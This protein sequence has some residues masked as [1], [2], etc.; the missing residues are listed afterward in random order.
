MKRWILPLL[1]LVLALALAACGAS[2]NGVAAGPET[3]QDPT[4]QSG[5][6]QPEEPD[7]G[8]P[9][10]QGDN[11]VPHEQVFY[12]GNTITE[13][14]AGLHEEGE[15]WDVSFWGGDSVELSDLL[16][17]LDYSGEVCKC[18]PEYTVK[19]ELSTEHYGVSLTAGYVRHSGGQAALT[20]EQIDFIRSILDRNPPD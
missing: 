19:T 11:I 2:A 7:H 16:A 4:A 17:Y 5:G 15:D 12:C 8:H 3:V 10:S 18:L 20:Q 9:L 14:S 1:I 13:I 6:A